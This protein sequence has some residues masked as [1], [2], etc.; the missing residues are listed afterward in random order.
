MSCHSYLKPFSISI[1]SLQS[2]IKR[3]LYLDLEMMDL[4]ELRLPAALG[5]EWLLSPLTLTS[6]AIIG[7]Q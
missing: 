7:S 5:W 4:S 1:F 6:T 3:R 2:K